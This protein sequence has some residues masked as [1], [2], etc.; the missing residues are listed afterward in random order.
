LNKFNW[1]GEFGSLGNFKP[2]TPN[3]KQQTP[4]TKQQTPNNKHQ[5]INKLV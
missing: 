4:N 2:Q 1:F 3:D 5:T